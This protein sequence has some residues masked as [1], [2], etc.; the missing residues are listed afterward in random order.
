M[1]TLPHQRLTCLQG[2]QAVP[3]MS[4]GDERLLSWSAALDTRVTS[5]SLTTA[6]PYCDVKLVWAPAIKGTAA[7]LCRAYDGS[8][9]CCSIRPCV[10]VSL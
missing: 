9:S 4:L 2:L 7:C 5:D 6:N 10:L 3:Y 1:G 8:L